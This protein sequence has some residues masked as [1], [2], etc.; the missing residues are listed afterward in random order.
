[1]KITIELTP[2]QLAILENLVQNK[3]N[4]KDLQDLFDKIDAAIKNGEANKLSVGGNDKW[5]PKR[6]T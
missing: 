4:N 1:M 2:A 6:L 5:T 3:V